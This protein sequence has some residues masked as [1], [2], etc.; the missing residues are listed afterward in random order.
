MKNIIGTDSELYVMLER[1]KS[2]GVL[3]YYELSGDEI[4]L[5]ERLV[6][7][8]LATKS[9]TR[10]TIHYFYGADGHE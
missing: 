5:L 8:K 10:L 9:S 2:R 3:S 6:E 7:M 1:L 4:S